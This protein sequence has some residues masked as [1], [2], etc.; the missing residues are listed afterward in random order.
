MIKPAHKLLIYAQCGRLQKRVTLPSPSANFTS[1][2]LLAGLG[3]WACFEMKERRLWRKD[4][5]QCR[6]IGS[7]MPC[8]S[9]QVTNNKFAHWIDENPPESTAYA[10]RSIVR[11]MDT[12]SAYR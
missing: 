6:A 12:I 11:Q 5:R 4:P 10:M 9:E 1:A 3:W 8:F 7:V 2:S